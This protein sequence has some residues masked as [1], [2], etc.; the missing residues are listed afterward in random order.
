MILQSLVSLYD[1]LASD[2]ATSELLPRRGYSKQNIA[3]SVII[4]LSGNLVAIRAVTSED[5]MT[6]DG[7]SAHPNPQSTQDIAV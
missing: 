1:R 2:P 3:F 5:A 7:N 6:A 4:D